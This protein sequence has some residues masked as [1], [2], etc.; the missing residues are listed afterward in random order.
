VVA[1][2]GD[3]LMVRPDGAGCT[4]LVPAAFVVSRRGDGRPQLSHGWCRTIDGVQGGTWSEVHLLGTV[5]LDRYRGYVGQSRASSGTHTW[6]TRPA[7]PGDHGGRLI[8]GAATPAEEVLSALRRAEPKTFAAFDDPYR[9][10]G[11]LTRECAE[12]RLVLSRRPRLEPNALADARAALAAAEAA[13]RE[14]EERISYW[15]CELEAAS[16]WGRLRR[17]AGWR[18]SRAELALGASEHALIGAEHQLEER[19]EELAGVDRQGRACRR[20]DHAEGWRYLH[21]H[22]LERQVAEHW[23]VVVLAAARA[24]QPDAYGK[25]RLGQVHQTL[26]DRRRVHPADPAIVRDLG[27]LEHAV[28]SKRPAPTVGGQQS[29]RRRAAVVQPRSWPSLGGHVNEP[30]RAG[31]RGISL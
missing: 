8:R 20:F 19:R 26:L 13:V 24:G 22:Q 11:A 21:I 18:H 5:A 14:S 30:A 9:I 15:R 10:A 16:G 12:H 29:S 31:H 27:D 2:G 1:A 25:D 7:D 23:V 6:N 3:G 17:G 4:V 28:V